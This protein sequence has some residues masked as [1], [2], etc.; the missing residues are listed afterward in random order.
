M[1]ELARL[2]HD[3]Q[4]LAD[5]VEDIHSTQDVDDIQLVEFSEENKAKGDELVTTAANL[6]CDLLILDDGACHWDNIRYLRERGFGVEALESDNFGWLLGG[7]LTT[8]GY[9]LYG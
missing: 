6:A 7:I 3:I 9:I 5:N 1:E 2:L 4:N 8:K